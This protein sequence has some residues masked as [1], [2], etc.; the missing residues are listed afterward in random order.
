MKPEI[1]FE[2][3]HAGVWQTAASMSLLD[4]PAQGWQGR[5]Y[6]GYAADYALNYWNQR[7]AAA[8]AWRFPVGLQPLQAKHWPGFVMDLLPQ[9][10]G[11]QELLRQ[12][13]L[14]IYAEASADWQ[15]LRCGAAN[16]IGNCRVREAVAWVQERSVP[17][18]QGFSFADVAQRGATFTEYLAQ[19]GLFVAGSSAVQGEWPKILLTETAAGDLFLDHVL[20]DSLAKRHWLVKFARGQDATLNRILELE[21]V[22][23]AL[24]RFLGLR[25]HGQPLLKQRALFIPRFDREWHA[26][27]LVRHAQESLYAL[28]GCSGFGV[29]LS[30]N[31]ACY[32]LGQ[33]ATDPQTEILEY[34]RRD[35]AN[36]VL[37]NKDN[38][39]R[40]TAIQRHA[41]GWVGLTPVFDF[42]PMVLHPDGI[43]RAMRWEQGDTGHPDWQAAARQAAEAG[44]VALQPLLQGL[45]AMAAKV[46]QLPQQ[47][48]ALGVD[49]ATIALFMPSIQQAGQQLQVCGHG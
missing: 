4:A 19:H 30:H 43:A 28:C 5:V 2:I 16:P 46:L 33:A 42:A 27:Q 45:Q 47:M 38:H 7:D 23:M 11:R 10:Y 15:L 39:G 48:Q 20:P 31:T 34:L 17:Q 22:W 29:Q 36:V 25:V 8:L 12:L 35:V 24:A 21:A 40:N 1:T 26:G 37:G 18:P 13:G 44:N 32:W 14:S 41:D 3:F 6:L 9:G 49:A